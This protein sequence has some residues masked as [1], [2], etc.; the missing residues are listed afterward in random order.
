MSIKRGVLLA[1]L[2]A[3][4]ALVVVRILQV[5][6]ELQYV[7]LA[8]K[9]AL[10]EK[11][12]ATEGE[13][14]E[15]GEAKE[16]KEAEEKEKKDSA[17]VTLLKGLDN[18]LQENAALSDARMAEGMVESAQLKTSRGGGVTARVI[19]LWGDTHVRQAPLLAAGRLLYQEELE[20]GS[21][22]A[23][24]DEQTA[25]KL[26]R[27]GA[28]VG[29][30]FTLNEKEYTVAGIIRHTRTPGDREPLRVHVPLLSLDKLGLQADTLAV[31]LR[32]LPG[33]GAA[34]RLKTILE[35]WQKEGTLYNLSKERYRSL[36]PFRWLL[37]ALG[38]MALWLFMRGLVKITQGLYAQEKRQMES[39]YVS[40]RLHLWVLKGAG[41]L[42]LWAAWLAG[43][44]LVLNQAIAP[45]YMFPEW[46]PAVLVEPKD[47]ATAFWNNRAAVS[48]L[49]EIRTPEIIDLR[50]YH[51]LSAAASV[52]IFILLLKPYHR[53]LHSMKDA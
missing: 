17:L 19:G 42:L 7:T 8:P 22:V 41:M 37:C 2:V 33:Q 23:V 25:V 48:R 32:I 21:P 24:L 45:V 40:Q 4:A 51:R 6:R 34:T 52:A 46:V 14:N 49:V 3:L 31:S 44:Y 26:F 43:L 30:K 27:S 1:L 15:E 29:E 47:I 38:V 13:K 5:P 18:T 50:F 12:A 16:E 35:V 39:R 53:L 36:L 11:K 20:A 10:E 28:P 9:M